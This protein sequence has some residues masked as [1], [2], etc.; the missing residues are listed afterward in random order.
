AWDTKANSAAQRA[1]FQ[2]WHER[3][4]LPHRDSPGLTQFI[5][6][7]LADAFPKELLAEW[8]RLLDIEDD[9]ERRQQLEDYLDKG[10]GECW[11][12][13][14]AIADIC[15]ARFRAFHGTQYVLRAWCVMTNHVHVLVKVTTVP[16]SAVVKRW[17]GKTALDSNAL[18]NRN[19]PFWAEDYWDT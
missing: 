12:R 17:K 5:T 16:M 3:G 4:Y 9:R 13:P 18:L 10:H 7:H 19:G 8:A 6:Y 2:G 1:G 11:L 14:P 15:D